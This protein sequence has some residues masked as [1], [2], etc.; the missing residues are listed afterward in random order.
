MVY[1]CDKNQNCLLLRI[2]QQEQT[3]LCCQGFCCD[4]KKIYQL[5]VKF[6][7]KNLLKFKNVCG[8]SDLDMR[9]VF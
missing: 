7:T 4:T 3:H 8:L 5:V 9:R 1:F 6:C 2:W